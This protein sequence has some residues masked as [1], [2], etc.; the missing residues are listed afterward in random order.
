MTV[1]SPPERLIV[2]ILILGTFE[3]TVVATAPVAA[4]FFLG[5]G[6]ALLVLR[7]K[8]PD[9]PRPYRVSGYP[10]TPLLFCACSVVLILSSAAY[11]FSQGMVAPLVTTGVLLSGLLVYRL[12]RV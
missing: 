8:E 3:R 11:A 1:K 9:A 6:A 2:L 4:L 7:R 10:F 5:T 12:G